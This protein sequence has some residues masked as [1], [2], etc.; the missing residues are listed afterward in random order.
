MLSNISSKL[1]N[2][3][4]EFSLPYPA[5]FGLKSGEPTYSSSYMIGVNKL[6][7]ILIDNRFTRQAIFVAGY[8]QGGT[9]V[10]KAIKHLIRMANDGDRVARDTMLKIKG[11]YLI[12]NPHRQPGHIVGPDPGGEGISFAPADGWWGD[13]KGRVWEI[14]AQGDIIGS[15]DP[16]TT[17]LKRLPYYVDMFSVSDPLTFARDVIH[18]LGLINAVKMYPELTQG[19]EGLVRYL[20]RW[21]N[22]IN[23]LK[24][25]SDSLVHN[26]Y[27]DFRIDGRRVF[28]MILDDIYKKA[29]FS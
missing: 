15:S 7:K 3:F 20:S 9:V 12:A 21:R 10:T 13:W 16:N 19:G 14:C 22:T 27:A 26:R 29:V 17:L 11:I 28:D 25:Y 5:A 23:Q 8:S 18:E 6:V 2:E 24:Y 1:P 4:Q